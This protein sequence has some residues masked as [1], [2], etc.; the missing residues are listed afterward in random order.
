MIFEMRNIT[1]VYDRVIA[2]DDVS[3]HLNK[4]E[5]LAIVGEF[6]Y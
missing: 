5:I 4:G 1:K 3:L 2:N 6:S